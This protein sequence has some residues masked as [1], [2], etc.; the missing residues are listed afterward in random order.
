MKDLL[1]KLLA[2]EG[3]IVAIRHTMGAGFVVSCSGPWS[4]YINQRSYCGE[5][6]DEAL[7]AAVEDRE[8]ANENE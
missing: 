4:G 3:D 5:T 2:D 8:E 7:Q 6:I 1:E